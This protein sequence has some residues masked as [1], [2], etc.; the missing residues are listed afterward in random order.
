MWFFGPN[1]F[2]AI[3]NGEVEKVR[4]VLERGTKALQRRKD[5][6]SPL[7][8][9]VHYAAQE[10]DLTVR[11]RRLDIVKLLLEKGADPNDREESRGR[12]PL[13]MAAEY[14]DIELVDLLIRYRADVNA[15]D[16]DG[17]TPL[18][19]AVMRG[20]KHVAEFL[21]KNRA[22]SNAQNK[23]GRTPLHI[24]ALSNN[25]EL[26]QLLLRYGANPQKRDAA[27]KTPINLTTNEELA[28]LLEREYRAK[29]R[30][31][32]RAEVRNMAAGRDIPVQP[33]PPHAAPTYGALHHRSRLREP[34]PPL[35][36]AVM[37][38]NPGLLNLLLSKGGNPNEVDNRGRT[39]LHIAAGVG[40]RDCAVL[41]IQAG[42]DVNAR[43][44][45]GRT[46]LHYAVWYGRLAVADLLLRKGAAPNAIDNKGNTPLHYAVKKIRPDLVEL[47]L[48]HGAD[49]NV[50]G[51]RGTTPL[52][53]AVATIENVN[54]GKISADLKNVLR[55]IDLLLEKEDP[56]IPN[57]DGWTPLH[58]AAKAGAVD[59][60]AKLLERHANPNA[61]D[62]KGRT[63]LHIAASNGHGAVVKLLLQYGA[64]ICARDYRRRTPYALATGDAK[65]E[66][67]LILKKKGFINC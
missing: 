66:L 19:Y 18:H 27:G 48:Q 47:L 30:G 40:C 67:E 15:P 37:N 17:N 21:L 13:H 23:D 61:T 56:N 63:P 57:I 2:D 43:D 62:K 10:R 54:K 34:L 26:A 11:R 35:H 4:D 22:N 25:I 41:L 64:D 46:P 52:Y 5:G 53:L 8:Y 51:Y 42:A 12:T 9:A 45:N 20:H 50:R 14:G 58:K 3:A 1:I 36:D 31:A 39:P 7:H 32:Y 33:P 65:R 49:P 38:R 6:F 16:R 29:P 55:M 44:K 24:T 59:V 60:V 28:R